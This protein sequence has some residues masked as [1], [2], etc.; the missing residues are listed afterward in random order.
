[1]ADTEPT[2][3]VFTSAALGGL[4][5]RNRVIRSAAF[6]G[7][8]PGGLPSQGLID[9]HA[10]VARGG[11]GMTTV[12]YAAVSSDGLTYPHQICMDRPG[13]VGELRKLTD[14]V[15]AGCAAASIQLGHAGYFSA[16]PVTGVRPMGASRVF[17][18]Y[19]LTFPRRMK[20]HDIKTV[21]EHFGR[22]CEQA[23]DAGFDAVAIHAGHGYLLSQFLSP[24][25][26][27]RKD[28]WG[29][30]LENRSRFVVEVMRRVRKAVGAGFPVLVK[31]NL[32]DGFKGGL[33][34]EEACEIARTLEAESADALILSGGFVSKTPMYIMRGDTP[35]KEFYQGQ[36]SLTKKL[37]LL[38]MGR[39]MVKSFP[40]TETYF[41]EE[42]R[43]IREA[44]SMPLVLV[45]GLRRIDVMESAVREGFQFLAMARPLIMEPD[46]IARMER[47]EAEESKCEPCNKCVAAMDKEAMRC[48]LLEERQ[49]G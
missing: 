33:E 40:F 41:L 31:M 24:Y 4:T 19:T 27:R 9:Y 48:V 6:E 8:C 43:K 7:M 42:S 3:Q 15:H 30:S 46:L 36:K 12:A 35:F 20:E 11:V 13:V 34:L 25:T 49:G 2:R 39:I 44:V 5:L 47:G 26:N 38:L 10:E 45:G 22:A 32:R 37:G 28:R 18:S 14:A 16:K 21:V 23:R 17:N 1:M 29:G